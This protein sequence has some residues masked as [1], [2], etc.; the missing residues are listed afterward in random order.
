MLLQAMGKKVAQYGTKESILL[1]LNFNG[2]MHARGKCRMNLF[3]ESYKYWVI[4]QP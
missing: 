4:V 3:A 2:K 1:H